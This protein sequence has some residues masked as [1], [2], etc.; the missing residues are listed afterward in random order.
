MKLTDTDPSYVSEEIGTPKDYTDDMYKVYFEVADVEE[1]IFNLLE[2]YSYAPIEKLTNGYEAV[3]HIQMIPDIIRVISSRN[4]AIYQ[5][6]RYA[7]L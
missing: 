5:V 4:I 2:I 7:K 1:K 6:I 3:L